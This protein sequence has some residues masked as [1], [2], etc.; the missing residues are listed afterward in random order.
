MKTRNRP[1]PLTLAVCGTALVLTACS[2]QEEPTAPAAG[3]VKN[4]ARLIAAIAYKF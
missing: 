4:E 1:V 2:K 3:R